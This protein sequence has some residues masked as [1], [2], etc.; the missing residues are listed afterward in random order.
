MIQGPAQRAGLQFAAGLVERMVEETT[1]GTR[2]RSWPTR[3]VSCTSRPEPTADVTMADYEAWAGSSV[4]CRSAP[5][6]SPRSLSRRGQGR[7]GPANP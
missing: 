1:G 6:G 5:S 2:C 7:A 3:C 4:P